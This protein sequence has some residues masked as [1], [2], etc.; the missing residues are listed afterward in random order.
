MRIPDKKTVGRPPVGRSADGEPI[1]VTTYPRLTVIIEQGLKDRL[2]A[3]SLLTGKPVYGIIADALEGH[4]GA[5]P[6]EDRRAIDANVKRMRE[7]RTAKQ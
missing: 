4:L 2:E 7:Y 1:P 3:A 6:A 5:L